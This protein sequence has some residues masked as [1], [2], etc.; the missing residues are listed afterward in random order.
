MDYQF[1]VASESFHHGRDYEVGSGFLKS[2]RVLQHELEHDVPNL[3]VSNPGRRA[4]ISSDH[5]RVMR[6][7]DVAKTYR[8]VGVRCL[9]RAQFKQFLAGHLLG[10]DIVRDRT[11]DRTK[12]HCYG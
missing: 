1:L 12:K 3:P 4:Y 7:G 8:V 10:V 2:L 6:P 5:G 11:R 9:R